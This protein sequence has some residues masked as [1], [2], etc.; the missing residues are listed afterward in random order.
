MTKFKTEWSH[1]PGPDC[2]HPQDR[3][4]K[5]E[6]GWLCTSCQTY[7]DREM[8]TKPK[9]CSNCKPE[10]GKSIFVDDVKN[11]VCQK[12]GRKILDDLSKSRIRKN[13]ESYSIVIT[14]KGTDGTNVSK[15]RI[16]M[17]AAQVTRL[18][19]NLTFLLEHK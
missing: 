11:P 17:T 13:N 8:I 14:M 5:N 2:K 7:I 3:V 9:F 12:C 16:G 10:P 19:G 6:L 4:I 15:T 1:I 18:Y